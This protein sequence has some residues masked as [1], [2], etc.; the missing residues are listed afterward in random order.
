MRLRLKQEKKLHLLSSK[1]SSSLDIQNTCSSS[2]TNS[3]STFIMT[4]QKQVTPS[5]ATKSSDLE[6]LTAFGLLHPTPLQ[7]LLKTSPT[8][9]PNS[10]KQS[11][12]RK[13]ALMLFIRTLSL[14]L[15]HHTTSMRTSSLT[16]QLHIPLR[17]HSLSNKFE[18][19]KC[20]NGTMVELKQNII[21]Y[22]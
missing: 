2:S 18:R 17:L 16:L 3:T 14:C 20:G 15:L 13:R 1:Q 7:S 12:R 21:K 10:V 22:F 4:K 5:T 6:S 11:G 19:M 9:T 8:I